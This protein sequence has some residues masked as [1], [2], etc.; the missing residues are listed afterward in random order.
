M[1]RLLVLNRA[2]VEEL[3]DL[4]ELLGALEA[5]FRAISAGETSVPPR[6]AALSPHGLL[7][8]MPAWLP[9]TM[10]TKLVSVFPGNH[11]HGLPSHQALIA[12]FDETTG[13]PLALLDGTYIT[14][15]RTAAASGVAT[16][17]LAR[18]DARRVAILGG[19]VQGRSHERV[20]REQLGFED[21][22]L[23]T[24]SGGDSFEDAVRAADVVCC[25]TDALEPI[26][27]PQWL[28]PG[29]HV[30]SV[31]GSP[32]GRGELPADLF[33]SPAVSTFVETRVTF[34]PAPSGA[35]ELAGLD[36]ALGTELGEAL[37]G[38]R[39][40]RRTPEEITVYK[41]VGHAV[42]DAAAARLVYDRA[43]AA[44]AGVTI[45]I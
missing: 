43:V 18:P 41:S 27:R 24:R 13:A 42:E 16:R 39:P 5:G 40:G 30:N 2:E 22:R 4:A 7:G 8:A 17:L 10:S 19:G 1:P 26:L 3:L 15:I 36:A 38:T 21:V 28:R 6:I 37:A 23:V 20:F 32:R 11:A 25:C 9:G 14:A 29:T 34:S 12:L 44:G 31:G 33:D 35:P 45:T